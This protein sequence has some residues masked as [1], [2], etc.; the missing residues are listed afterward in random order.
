[1]VMGKHLGQRDSWDELLCPM[2]IE[3]LWKLYR[4]GNS[5]RSTSRRLAPLVRKA[6]R[7]RFILFL[8]ISSTTIRGDLVDAAL[9]WGHRNKVGRG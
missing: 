1:M 3:S 2:M 4:R 6:P 7:P 8:M 5:A 9:K